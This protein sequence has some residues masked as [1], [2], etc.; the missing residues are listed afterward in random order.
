MGLVVSI[1][2]TLASVGQFAVSVIVLSRER[3]VRLSGSRRREASYDESLRGQT[4]ARLMMLAAALLLVAAIAYSLAHVHYNVLPTTEAGF[5]SSSSAYERQ[6]AI[7]IV[8]IVLAVGALCL[9]L[10]SVTLLWGA[11]AYLAELSLV[12]V[13]GV[14]SAGLILS[15]VVLPVISEAPPSREQ[16][17]RLSGEHLGEI[18][19]RAG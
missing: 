6:K 15:L 13:V 8:G 2:A 1:I 12:L 19:F 9:S 11:R 7:D 5:R 17:Y 14:I 16:I 3:N 10:W 4:S 18:A